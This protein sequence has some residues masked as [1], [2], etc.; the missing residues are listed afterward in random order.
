MVN[1]E[2][3]LNNFFQRKG[4]YVFLHI[5]ILVLSIVLVVAI[6]IDTFHNESFYSQ[7]KF[8]KFQ[9]WVCVVFLLDFFIEFFLSP[10]KWHYLATHFFFFLVSIPYNN[11]IIH[12]GWTFDPQITYCLRY[13]PLIRGGY[14]MAIVV[15]WFTYN[16]ATGLFISYLATLLFTVYFASLAFFLFEHNVNP[17]VKDYDDALWWAFMDATTVGSNIVAVTTI[18]RI[19]SVLLA[20]LGMMMFPIFTVYVTNILTRHNKQ[21]K[22]LGDM[23]FTT[24][25]M[26]GERTS[27]KYASDASLHDDSAETPDASGNPQAAQDDTDASGNPQAPQR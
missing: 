25:L 9:F 15:S 14:A 7:P 12:Y 18:G 4:I 20:A 5:L 3:Q 22:Q 23:A 26:S 1:Q 27:E 21:G 17:L 8:I 11:I 6:S 24:P 16:K 10:N 13:I 2:T 19:L